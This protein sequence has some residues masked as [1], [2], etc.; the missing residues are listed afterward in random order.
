MNLQSPGRVQAVPRA[1]DPTLQSL[2]RHLNKA[3]LCIVK[4]LDLSHQ[5]AGGLMT[6][7]H[8]CTLLMV[9]CPLLLFEAVALERSAAV[10]VPLHVVVTGD[11]H[12]TCIHWA[13]P[14]ESMGL[15]LSPAVRGPVDTLY[16]RVTRV[17]EA[18][19]AWPE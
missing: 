1:L 15:R 12:T 4:Q 2:R 5:F 11:R 13:H 18:S 6:G 14:A 10:F 3:G 8:R 16:S 7:T 9:D 17:I 19:H